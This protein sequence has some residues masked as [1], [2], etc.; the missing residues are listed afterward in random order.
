MSAE[1][2]LCYHLM[3]VK[4]GDVIKQ[5]CGCNQV[6]TST[7]G[8]LEPS[9]SRYKGCTYACEGCHAFRVD[10]AG[11]QALRDQLHSGAKRLQLPC[12]FPEVVG[13]VREATA[14]KGQPTAPK[15]SLLAID[16]IPHGAASR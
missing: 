3:Q 2:R 16:D 6:A 4:I 13:K 12:P 11:Q 7:D 15:V 8:Q 14:K 5:S 1:W 10:E 9:Y